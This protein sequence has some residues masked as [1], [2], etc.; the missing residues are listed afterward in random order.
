M[1]DKIVQYGP[2]TPQELD[3]LVHEL[4]LRNIPFEI[5]KDEEAE[6]K[7]KSNN[8]SN[9][10]NQISYRNEQYLGQIFYITLATKDLPRMEEHLKELG[11]PIDLPEFSGE[12]PPELDNDERENV[13]V[14]A[15]AEKT[16]FNRRMI[17][18]IFL[19]GMLCMMFISYALTVLNQP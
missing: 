1:S 6:K 5:Q 9:I 12:S 10:V 11:F 4:Q 18:W 15:R 16:N 13:F 7:F 19:I 2:L 14:K 8:F 3:K 17:A